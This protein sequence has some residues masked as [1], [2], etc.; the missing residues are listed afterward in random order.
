M[1]KGPLLAQKFEDEKTVYILTTSHSAETVSKTRHGQERTIPKSIDTYNKNMGGVNQIDQMLEPYDAT[2]KPVHWYVKLAIH[3]IQIAVLNGWTLY[4]KRG[5]Q[6]DFYAYSRNVIA[7]LVFR[8]GVVPTLENETSQD[9]QHVISS[10][11]FLRLKV[12]CAHKSTA[13]FVT[14]EEDAETHAFIV[15]AVLVNS[16]FALVNAL[17][18]T[19]LRSPSS[20]NHWSGFLLHLRRT[21]T[22]IDKA[23]KED[24][25]LSPSSI[26]LLQFS[27]QVKAPSRACQS[28]DEVVI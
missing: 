3:L 12:N 25:D 22:D 14:K 15:Q 4:R 2:R 21:S 1:T 19:P 13:R 17:R 27:N 24:R 5:G 26:S 16:D 9:L 18:S 28:K 10:M 20:C 6:G 7:S 23:F 11:K 8:D